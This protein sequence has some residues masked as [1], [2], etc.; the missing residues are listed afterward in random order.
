MGMA[1]GM[2]VEAVS[3]MRMGELARRSGLGSQTIHYY[4][5]RGYLHPPLIK[6]G[7]QAFY[8]ETHLER[9]RL[10]KRCKRKNIPFAFCDRLEESEGAQEMRASGKV[11]ARDGRVDD[12]HAGQARSTAAG[13][14]V[15]WPGGISSTRDRIID[16]GSR[17]FLQRGYRG[18]TITEIMNRVGV[19]KATFYYYFENKKDLY[20][21]CLDRVFETIFVEA[22]ERIKQEEDPLK[23][24]ELRMRSSRL[25]LAEMITILDL[26]KESL[27][28]EDVDHR[29]RAADILHK[30]LVDPLTRDVERGM[31][32]GVFRKVNSEVVV[33]IIISVLETIAYHPMISEKITEA[34]IED[35]ML[36]FIVHAL[37]TQA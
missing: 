25:F 10:L 24:F 12:G 15:G 36:D 28:E 3:V 31:R 14:G 5:R 21:V 7:N 37:T 30:A 8:D 32:K 34:E 4:L 18:T 29:M 16:V 20:F 19:T 17:V 11:R 23:R 22:L 33:F 27:R 1:V 13:R 26:I 9:L 6:D 2:A 35:I